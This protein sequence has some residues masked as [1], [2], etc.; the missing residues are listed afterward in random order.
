MTE[1]SSE[2]IAIYYLL[3]QTLAGL[4]HRELAYPTSL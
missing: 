2:F 1:V 3:N 4:C